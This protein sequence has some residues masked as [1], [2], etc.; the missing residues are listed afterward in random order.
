MAQSRFLNKCS[1]KLS[2]RLETIF[3]IVLKGLEHTGG[4]ISTTDFACRD[5]S[6]E[7]IVHGCAQCID[8]RSL[9]DRTPASVLLWRHEANG[10]NHQSLRRSGGIPE[11]CPGNTEIAYLDGSRG[12]DENVGGLDVQVDHS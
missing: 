11:S 1:S 5:F 4:N 2:D 6:C 7:G 9:G 8:I 10:S 12:R 3:G